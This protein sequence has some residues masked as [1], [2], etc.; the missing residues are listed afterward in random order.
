MV[1]SWVQSR[2]PGG[3]PRTV[4]GGHLDVIAGLTIFRGDKKD[5]QRTGSLILLYL[6]LT[7]PS[8]VRSILEAWE[9]VC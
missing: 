6:S 5:R 4:P 8:A 7:S 1:W 9:A 3:R 2:G